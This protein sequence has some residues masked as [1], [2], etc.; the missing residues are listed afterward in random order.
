MNRL[1]RA[2]GS[3]SALTL[4]SRILGLVRDRLMAQAFGARW[5]QGTFLVAWMFPN[6][7]RRL[8]GEGALSAA[9]VPAYTAARKRDPQ[10][11]RELL[12]Q[13]LGNVTTILLPVCIVVAIVSLTLPAEWLPAPEKG[14]VEAMRLLLA[15]NAVLFAYALPVCLCA[16]LSGA[17]NTLGMFAL[18]A[19]VPVLLNVFWIAALLLARPLGFS[20]DVEIA[21]FAAWWLSIGGLL[22]LLF[23]IVPMLRR[24]ELLRPRLG[25]PRRGTPAFAVFVAMGPMVVGMSLNQIS[26]LLDTLMAYYLVSSG[27][28]TYIYLANR[29]LLFPHALTAMSL[30]VAAFPKLALEATA[31]DRGPVRRTLDQFAGHTIVVTLPASVGLML[32]ADDVVRVLFV[33]GEFVAGDVWPTVLTVS[34]LVAGLPFLGLAQLYARAFYAVGDVRTPARLAA[35]LVALNALLNLAL[36]WLTPLGTAGL[37]LASSLSSLTNAAILARRF[38]RH[39]PSA[40]NAHLAATWIRSLIATAVMSIVVVSLR[41]ATAEATHWQLA[42]RNLVI[43]I[44][45]GM[46]AYA[47]T[48]WLLGSRELASL[49]RG[50]RGH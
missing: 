26:S 35:C 5:I 3:I 41:T 46:A 32:L 37:A 14:G 18:P 49:R 6:L 7:M 24:S 33:G 43:P 9:L 17:M 22:Q 50:G 48:H 47:A 11:A 44:L 20:V 45:G 1:L 34:C 13:V 31:A 38:R 8:L 16:V 12:A 30:G 42:W 40:A 10:A 21:N 23:L 4:V 15:L 27:A 29:L 36:L 25:L 19:T 39:V 2:A 28:V